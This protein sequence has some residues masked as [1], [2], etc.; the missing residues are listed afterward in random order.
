[1]IFIEITKFKIYSSFKKRGYVIIA[2]L[3]LSKTVFKCKLPGHCEQS[4]HYSLNFHSKYVTP[5]TKKNV[6]KEFPWSISLQKLVLHL[7][8]HSTF[9]SKLA[10]K[11]IKPPLN[12]VTYLITSIFPTLMEG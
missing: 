11:A 2:K 5:T 10:T 12:Q 1:M 7:N 4:T 6:R 9:N 8:L 3:S